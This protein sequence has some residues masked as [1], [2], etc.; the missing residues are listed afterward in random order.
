MLRIPRIVHKLA[1]SYCLAALGVVA[2][3][4]STPTPEQKTPTKDAS[5][6]LESDNIKQEIA[7]LRA[8]ILSLSE[9]LR[10]SEKS[11]EGLQKGF[12]SGIFD[13]ESATTSTASSPNT[14]TLD[15]PE[16]P[17]DRGVGTVSP[18]TS[19]S[20]PTPTAIV[21]GPTK[22]LADTERLIYQKKYAE[23]MAQLGD[24]ERQFPNSDDDGKSLLLLAECSIAL[25]HPEDAVTSMRRFYLKYPKSPDFLAA[26]IKEA[27]AHAALGARERALKIYQ[28]VISLGPKT[29]H[30]Q[31]ARTA[32]QK[33]RD[34]R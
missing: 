16:T 33:L 8:E 14:A 11:I 3:C 20:S 6:S 17:Q 13:G 19:D 10:T 12:R 32:I 15:V 28:E 5:I 31:T 29:G 25:N 7:V 26:K 9:R 1:L 21:F 2:A 30:A 34:E 4:S 27:R 24:L 23:A 22:I 18:Q